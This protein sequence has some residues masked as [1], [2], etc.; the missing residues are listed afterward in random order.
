MDKTNASF[1]DKSYTAENIK[2]LEGLEAVRVRPAMYVGSTGPSGLHHLVY[3]VVDN[4]I[5][6]AM[7]GF[8]DKIEVTIHFDNSVT[9]N[10]NGRGIPVDLHKEEGR[11]AAE[12]VMTTLHAGGKFDKE[13]YKV[14]GGLHGV[15]VSVVNALSSKL[16]LEIKRGGNIY[17][18]KYA[19]GKP[20]SELKRMG[21]SA[22]RGT[23]IT[24]WPDEEIFETIEFNYS[25]LSRRLKE[26]AF[27]NKGLT[28]VLNDERVDKKEVFFFKGGLIEFVKYLVGSKTRIHTSP[29]FLSTKKDDIEID[30]AFQYVE[31]YNETLLSFVNNINTVEGGTHLSGFKSGIT[32]TINNFAQANSL[33]KDFK[34]VFSGDDVREG[35]TAVVSIRIKD[36]QFEGQTKAKLGNSDVKGIVESFVNKKLSDF[37]DENLTVARAIINKVLLAAKAREASK[38]AKD[39]VRKSN[40]LENTTLPGKLAD[41]Q[42]RNPEDSELYIVEGDSAGGSA[43]QGRDRRFQAVLP[44]KGK[45]LNVEKAS[46]AKMLENEEIKKI[47]AA[48][49]VGIGKDM[50]NIEKLRYHKIVVMTDAD[51]DGSHIRTLIMTFFFRQMQSL[52]EKGFLYLAQPPLYLIK[53]GQAKVYLKNEKELE[54]HL[55]AK[56]GDE[57]IFFKKNFAGELLKGHKLVKFIKLVH[58]KN[59]LMGNL[60]KRGMPRPLTKKLVETIDSENDLRDKNKVKEISRQLRTDPVCRNLEIRFDKEYTTH[61]LD[62]EFELNGVSAHKVI[63]HSFL[64]GPEFADINEVYDKL[65][66]FPASPYFVEIGKERFVVENRKELVGILFD[67]LKKGLSIQ[68][69]KGLGEMNPDQLWE[70]TMDPEKRTLLQVG[71]NDFGECEEI[72]DTLMGNDSAKRKDFIIQNAL[73]VRNLDI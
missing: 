7:G 11:T 12:V 17:S 63:D 31:S 68:R 36:P 9:V 69:Y 45:I 61:I 65:A 2:V 15:G 25:V 16:E 73:D 22:R 21:K 30:I 59:L 24:F 28:I 53:K 37:F 41:C 51:V 50:Y 20:T 70:T 3:E 40:L 18:Q 48:L 67:R 13:S 55:F 42:S 8:C 58:K 54:N 14:S 5:D 29:I 52:V 62:I 39:L 72:F 44:L 26:L 10:D 19:F 66:E 43:K 27:L 56:I 49:G 57:V 64:T 47:I 46:T 35:L 32:R 60:E 34:D 71:V 6:E 1:D 4:S 23:K 33:T 38:K